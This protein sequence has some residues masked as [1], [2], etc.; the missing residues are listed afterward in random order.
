MKEITVVGGSFGYPARY[1][2]V[3]LQ[4][5][6]MITSGISGKR[7]RYVVYRAFITDEDAVYLKL[8]NQKEKII[9]IKGKS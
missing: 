5:V 3:N 1:K 8:R 9:P 7:N 4:S 2:N 6:R